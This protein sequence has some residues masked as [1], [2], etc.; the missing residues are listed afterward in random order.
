M[1]IPARFSANWSADELLSPAVANGAPLITVSGCANVSGTLDLLLSNS[2]LQAV[3]NSSSSLQ[4]SILSSPCLSGQFSTVELS[5]LDSGAALQ[6][7]IQGRQ[8]V[9]GGTLSVFV[10]N[11]P[12]PSSGPSVA[13]IVGCAV[14][15]V[16]VLVAVV[17]VLVLC[18]KRYGRLFG[19]DESPTYV[20]SP[21]GSSNHSYK[22]L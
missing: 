16:V 5:S 9:T 22:L 4:L 10:S 18:R 12:C 11:A 2:T 3:T 13:L 14:G 1:S 7:G 8:S 19:Y 17:T 15:G 20:I 6:C 21:S